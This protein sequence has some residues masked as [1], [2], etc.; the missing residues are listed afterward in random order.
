M[1]LLSTVI[2]VGTASSFAPNYPLFLVTVFINGFCSLGFGTVMY[3]WMME[4]LSGTWKTFYGCAPHLNYAVGGLLVAAVAYCVPEWRQMQLIFNIPLVLMLAIY[5]IL[6]ESPRWLLTHG[7]TDKA[8]EIVRRIASHNGKD[9]PS[10]FK[11]IPPSHHDHTKRRLSVAVIKKGAGHGILG[12]LDLFK[13]PNMRKKTLI[14][15]YCWFATSFVYYGLTL[16]SNDFGA[17]LFVYFSVGKGF[18]KIFTTL[19]TYSMG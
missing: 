11:L 16:N 3:C 9:L 13:T 8:E 10:E 2:V 12:F 15:Y 5:W 18:I 17:S 19:S 14:V 6:P 4:I 1:G 7:H